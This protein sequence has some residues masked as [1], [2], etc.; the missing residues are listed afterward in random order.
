MSLVCP[1]WDVQGCFQSW[2]GTP[3]LK[4]PLQPLQAGEGS[5]TQSSANPLDL[6][7]TSSMAE[8]GPGVHPAASS[9]RATSPLCCSQPC[10][11]RALWPYQGEEPRAPWLCPPSSPGN[12]FG[13]SHS[14]GTDGMWLCP[15]WTSLPTLNF[16]ALCSDGRYNF[17]DLPVIVL[18]PPISLKIFLAP[19][20]WLHI[21]REAAI[22]MERFTVF[23]KRI[24]L[25]CQPYL[26]SLP[27]HPS[28]LRNGWLMN[29]K[30]LFSKLNSKMTL[31][32][33]LWINRIQ[34]TGI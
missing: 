15:L 20:S 22:S 24:H 34:R 27:L 28:R 30:G 5:V 2:S 32:R 33:R 1:R 10:S 19:Y 29:K 23:T 17:P 8:A 3:Q 12:A 11:L 18:H 7:K 21:P 14:L 16:S 31:N 9:G 26:A 6:H 25:A 4:A 13:C